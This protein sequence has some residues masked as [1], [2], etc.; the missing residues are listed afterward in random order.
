MYQTLAIIFGLALAATG[1]LGFVPQ[2][3]KDGLLLGYFAVN[4]HHNLI[5]LATGVIALLCGLNSASASRVF[6]QVFGVIYA[7]V[8]ALGFYYGDSPI[9][10]LVAN[11]FADTIL[12]VGIAIVSLLIGF[13]L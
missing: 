9:F 11:N 7:I 10:G 12:H 4:L 5:H 13:V 1:A 6:F 8:A 3:F 2:A